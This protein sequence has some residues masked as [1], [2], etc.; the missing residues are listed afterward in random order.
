MRKL[1]G[2]GPSVI[3]LA[4]AAIVLFVGPVAVRQLTYEQTRTQ[5]IQAR[6]NLESNDLLQRL[7]QAYRDVASVVEPSVVHVSVHQWSRDDT[8]GR[9]AQSLSTGSGWVFDDLGHI[10]TNHHVI[11]EAQR[12]EVQM[13]DGSLR[14]ATHIG[15]DPLTD[16]AVIKVEPGRLHPAVIGDDTLEPV[17]Q[18]D[19]VFAFGSPFD[20]RF[21]MS[22]GVVSGKGRSVGVLRDSQGQRLGYENF[23]QVDAAINPGNSGGPLTDVRGRVIA[24]NTAI[25]T[26]RRTMGLDEGQFAGIGLAIPI[27]MV[28]PVVQQIIEKGYVTKGFLGVHVADRD[29][30]H[31]DEIVRQLGFRGYGVRVLSVN[32]EHP[33]ARA[34]LLRDDVIIQVNDLPVPAVEE[35][36]RATA[37]LDAHEAT[38]LVVWRYGLDENEGRVT[39]SVP[40]AGASGWRG[41]TLADLSEP[42]SARFDALQS[43]EPGVRV[44]RV[45]ADGPAANADVRRDDV[46][47]R[48]N[49][50][51]VSTVAQL[52]SV[53]SSIMPG[54]T[55]RLSLWR[56]DWAA[57]R[58]SMMTM[59]VPVA[60]LDELQ[61]GRLPGDQ[62]REAITELGIKRMTTCT[63]MDALRLGV[64]HQAGVLLEEFVEGS[65]LSKALPRGSIIVEVED[66]PVTNV[67]ELLRELG[68]FNL[69]AHGALALVV[70]PDGGSKRVEL[71]ME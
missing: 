20:F 52:Q 15:S 17:K 50:E 62:S 69:R 32:D 39:I 56:F 9:M 26:G 54:Q 12:I 71:R 68:R 67:N 6:H 60:R 36:R 42:L 55:A 61:Y 48:V 34:G 1:S 37:S 64:M 28:R 8:T 57:R 18:G 63:P 19:Q 21:S 2:Y 16:V 53:V 27:G 49:D 31:E 10:V 11:Q 51:P 33:A 14:E 44:I 43:P 13:Y 59:S 40:N 47:I 23:I 46:I 38:R 24:M 22:A 7:N 3:V 45:D 66:E 25:A 35:L 70:T 58:G 65:S 4:T 41:V 29:N 30:T 5:I